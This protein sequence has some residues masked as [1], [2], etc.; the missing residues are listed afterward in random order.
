MHPA[1]PI[2]DEHGRIVAPPQSWPTPR[3]MGPWNAN[4]TPLPKK[5]P[6]RMAKATVTPGT[7][8]VQQP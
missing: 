6:L 5:E 1:D 2:R 3:P 8:R 7:I 4:A